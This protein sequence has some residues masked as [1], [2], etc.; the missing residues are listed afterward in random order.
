M[1]VVALSPSFAFGFAPSIAKR[2]TVTLR[3]TTEDLENLVTREANVKPTRR[4]KPT[5]DP[6]NPRFEDIASV[7]Y[8]EAFP[9]STKE[10]KVVTH[11]PT[12]SSR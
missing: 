6:Y 3:S 10:Y 8:H 1:S 9:S 12:G 11:E 7:P 2:S 4:T 5:H